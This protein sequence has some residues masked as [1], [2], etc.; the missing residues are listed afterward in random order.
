M[1]FMLSKSKT[2]QITIKT[3][4]F[5]QSLVFFFIIKRSFAAMR[6]APLFYF[7]KLRCSFAL[8]FLF[9]ALLI[10]K[11]IDDNYSR[12]NIGAR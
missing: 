1:F 9:F 12:K 10:E 5:L 3:T 6:K 11:E 2:A 4:A 7:Y 8:A